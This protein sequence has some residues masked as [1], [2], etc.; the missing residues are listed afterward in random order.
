MS[1]I[2]RDDN[3]VLIRPE[4]D[5]VASTVDVLRAE[6]KELV[7][8]GVSQITLD[9]TEVEVIDSIGLGL[10]ISSHNSLAKAGGK[11]SVVKVSLE[12]H[13]LFRSMRLDRHFSVTGA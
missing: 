5:I 10:I 2:T 12:V 3:G 8:Q 7:G 13:D 9:L 1:K 6:L 4:G 11:L